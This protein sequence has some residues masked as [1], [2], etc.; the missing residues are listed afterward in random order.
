[1]N[2]ILGFSDFLNKPDLTEDKRRNYIKIIQNSGEQLLQIID[3]IIDISRLGTKQIKVIETEVNLNDL[4][5][6]LFSIFDIK[7]KENKTPL[8]LKNE[9]SDRESVIL[10]DRTKLLKII[11]N[12]L[13][14]SL[15]FTSEGY[16]NFGYKLKSEEIEIFVEDTGI[17][18]EKEKHEL[19]FERFTQAEKDLSKKMGGLGLGLSIVKEN[20]ELLGGKIRVQSEKGV[21]AKFLVT[22]PYKAVY[23]KEEIVMLEKDVQNKQTLLIAEDEEVNYLY[24]ETLIKEILKLDCELLHAKNGREAIEYCE[25]NPNIG[26]ILMDLKMPIMSGYESAQIIKK[27]RPDL[28]IIAQTA[29]SSIDD[30]EKAILI[31]FNDFLSKPIDVDHF[32]LLMNKYLN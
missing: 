22:I 5:L 12:L 31:G 24:L 11:S 30:K 7:A 23:K 29:Y 10:T 3:D 15:K 4:M 28:P 26:L 32:K 16:I 14:N 1:M 19:I 6:E 8:Y 25:N 2:G 20:V 18:V 13:E 27:L 17:G 9:L 21:G